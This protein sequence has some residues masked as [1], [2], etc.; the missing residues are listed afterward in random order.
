[1]LCT[2]V[3]L[4]FEASEWLI[5]E[6]LYKDYECFCRIAVYIHALFLRIV[7]CFVCFVWPVHCL[8][9]EIYSAW[10]V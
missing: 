1:M 7:Y 2:F 9:S 6:N 8:S 10:Q 5:G 4:K 3:W